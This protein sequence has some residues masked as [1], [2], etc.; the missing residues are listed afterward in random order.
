MS[1]VDGDGKPRGPLGPGSPFIP[2]APWEPLAPSGPGA[3][4]NSN[5]AQRL[6]HS[7][8]PHTATMHRKCQKPEKRLLKFF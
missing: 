3:P 5:R 8:E 4:V 2:G 1:N 7:C 6:N